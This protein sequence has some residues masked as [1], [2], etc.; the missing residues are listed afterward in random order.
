MT[1]RLPRLL[2]FL[3]SVIRVRITVECFSFFLVQFW[4]IFIIMGVCTPQHMCEGLEGNSV[5]SV[6][7]FP[8][9]WGFLGLS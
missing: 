9:L 5:K 2:P 6:L 3:P 4:S 1:T 8:P 7:A